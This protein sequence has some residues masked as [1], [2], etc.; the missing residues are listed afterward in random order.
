MKW[1]LKQQRRMGIFLSSAMIC[2]VLCGCQNTSES[3]PSTSSVSNLPT[4]GVSLT[5]WHYYGDL[6][7]NKLKL[8]V[9]DFNE[10]VGAENNITVKLVG[11]TSIA[12]LEVE[13]TQA[14]QGVVYA[15][16]MPDLFLA[17]PDKVLELQKLDVVADLSAYFT[18]EDMEKMIPDFVEAGY[19]GGE[20]SILPIVK[21]TELVFINETLWEE[22]AQI[23]GLHYDDLETWEGILEAAKAYYEYTDEQTPDIQNDGKALFGV[24]SLQ[25]YILVSCMQMGLDL[26]FAETLSQEGAWSSLEAAF[27]F[28]I[29]A[30]SYGYFANVGKFRTDDIRSGDI[31]AYV[32][33]SA[34]FPYFPDWIEVEEG[35]QEITWRALP[36][37]YFQG[38]EPYVL[39]QGAGVVVAKKSGVEEQAAAEFLNFFMEHNVD[40]AVES[41]YIPVV[42][43]FLG[44]STVGESFQSMLSDK[45]L[46][47]NEIQSYALVV[48]QIRDEI[49]YQ[50]QAFEGTYIVRTELAT[51]LE[52]GANTSIEIVRA[53]LAQGMTR[54]EIQAETDFSQQFY[55]IIGNIS[56][57]LES[58]N[59]VF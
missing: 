53:K 12:Q 55:Q 33:S 41:A 13:V 27:Q 50:P 21:S 15:E 31:L 58:Q 3:K 37:P 46:E 6:V 22:F 42:S 8:I 24:D 48:E 59:I 18:E 14:A 25:N 20:Q 44:E 1:H 36:Y 39:S 35:K 11:K 30:M 26:F 28:Y 19:V 40:F 17:Y 23:A 10:T 57:K 2:S 29:E 7:E 43:S 52:Q 34:S 5:F 4:E 51:A 47:E 45:D 56:A 16:E 49:L 9:N 38:G 54:E 32:G